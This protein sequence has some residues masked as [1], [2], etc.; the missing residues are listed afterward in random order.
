MKMENLNVAKG[1]NSI[2][3]SSLNH[4]KYIYKSANDFPITIL[5]YISK[6]K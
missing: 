2:Y 6:I 5:R 3:D 4:T 1:R